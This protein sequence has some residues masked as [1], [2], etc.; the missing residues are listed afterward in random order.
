MNISQTGTK[1]SIRLKIDG[2]FSG[3]E[4]AAI[5]FFEHLSKAIE[6]KPREILLDMEKT[7]SI[8]SMAIGLLVGLLIKS[9]DNGI[10]VRI[11]KISNAVRRILDMTY[12]IKG[13]PDLYE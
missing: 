11:D 13:F 9:R 8:D 1:D 3:M 12:L 7:S 4:E 2:S 10:V 6:Q 5:A